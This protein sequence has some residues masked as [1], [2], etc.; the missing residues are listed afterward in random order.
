MK[1]LLIGAGGI[2]SELCKL[3]NKA[4]SKN[5]IPCEVE[6]AVA[7]PDIVEEKNLMYQDYGIE[8][9]RKNKAQAIVNKYQWLAKAIPKE[10][11]TLQQVQGY[12][13]FILCVDNNEIRRRIFNYSYAHNIHFIDLRAEG[14]SI[15]A[16]TKGVGLDSDLETINEDIEH[17]SCQ[18]KAD[19]DKSIIQYGN[20]IISSIGLQLF[21][22]Y[23]RE[24][25]TGKKILMRI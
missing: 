20:I 5:Q 7:D 6:I 9:I 11:K 16:L 18:R 1:V 25:E 4:Y 13:L 15:M 24:N 21:L 2:G 3:I 14:R 23:L 19:L 8:D 22:N 12:D 10:I 17:G